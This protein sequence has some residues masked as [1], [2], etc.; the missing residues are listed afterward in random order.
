MRPGLLGAKTNQSKAKQGTTLQIKAN[1]SNA[2]QSTSECYFSGT[3]SIL[4]HRSHFHVSLSAPSYGAT[5]AT[6]QPQQCCTAC[7]GFSWCCTALIPSRWSC[8]AH[9]VV[10][11]RTSIHGDWRRPCFCGAACVLREAPTWDM[12]AL[13]ALFRA[14]DSSHLH[15]QPFYH[16]RRSVLTLP[17]SAD[18]RA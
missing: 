6:W 14:R 15:R 16:G 9:L 4:V 1:Q 17:R 7:F 10:R 3:R 18:G 13:P 5:V 12:R 8:T 11:W 2:K